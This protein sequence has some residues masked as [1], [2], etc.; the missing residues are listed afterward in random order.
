MEKLCR[1]NNDKYDIR[2]GKHIS[3]EKM[4]EIQAKIAADRRKLEEQKD[5]A[6]EERNKV[7]DDLL[8]KE[9]E[10]KKYQYVTISYSCLNFS[11]YTCE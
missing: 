11:S 7:Q 3:K 10:L 4:A 2:T 8:E 5:M 9:S 1:T 6:E